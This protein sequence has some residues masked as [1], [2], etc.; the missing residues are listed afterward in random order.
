MFSSMPKLIKDRDEISN[1]IEKLLDF[2]EFHEKGKKLGKA[3]KYAALIAQ[4]AII[5]RTCGIFIQHFIILQSNSDLI[6]DIKFLGYLYQFMH[7]LSST[8]SLATAILICACCI[9]FLEGFIFSMS[10][11]NSGDNDTFKAYQ[12]SVRY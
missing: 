2:Y 1:K 6:R 9:L 4:N 12:V 7:L 5:S 11:A 8:D 3:T 10:F